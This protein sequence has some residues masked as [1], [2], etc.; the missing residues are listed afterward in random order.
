MRSLFGPKP[1]YIKT[2]NEQEFAAFLEQLKLL[3]AQQFEDTV[4]ALGQSCVEVGD[5]YNIGAAAAEP[6]QRAAQALNI[7]AQC[8]AQRLG[9]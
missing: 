2:M 4:R 6:W 9:N 8:I 1:C 7:A 5:P 3:D